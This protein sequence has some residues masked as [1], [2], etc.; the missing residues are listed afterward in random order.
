[1][2]HPKFYR[3]K[4]AVVRVLRLDHDLL[5]EENLKTIRDFI[6]SN[7]PISKGSSHIVIHDPNDI[8]FQ[9]NLGDW[10]IRNAKGLL[11]PCDNN[12]FDEMYEKV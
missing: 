12:L 3:T 6:G 8:S 7:Y 9:V 11:S 5:K 1:M 10:I 4:P 2:K